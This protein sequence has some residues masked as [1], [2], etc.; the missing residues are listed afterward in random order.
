[1][2]WLKHN[3]KMIV[4]PWDYSRNLSSIGVS[5]ENPVS[6]DF[7][8]TFDNPDDDGEKL[9]IKQYAYTRDWKI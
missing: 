7:Q 3:V 5:I 2:L 4:R 9:Q 6:L 1:M 8:K